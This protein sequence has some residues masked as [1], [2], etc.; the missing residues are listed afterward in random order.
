MSASS[1]GGVRD[2]F[3]GRSAFGLVAAA[4]VSAALAAAAGC[5]GSAAGPSDPRAAGAVAPVPASAVPA[6]ATAA[7]K[8]VPPHP[9]PER[10]EPKK[11]VDYK[12]P[13]LSDNSRCYVCH[14]NLEDDPFV[15]W[16]AWGGAGCEKCHGASDDHCGDENHETAPDVMYAKAKIP[17]ACW[18][19]HPE[20]K[21]PKGFKPPV[22]ED[23]KKGCTDCHGQHRLE[24]R[25]RKWDKETRKLI[26]E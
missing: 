23:A 13:P 14:L 22:P 26:V 24:R 11:P 1:G 4:C 18:E 8:Q 25:Q 15:R 10:D 19:C 9:V 6:A 16:H 5:A 7:A 17:A 20:V 21:P 12:K 3:R 2:F